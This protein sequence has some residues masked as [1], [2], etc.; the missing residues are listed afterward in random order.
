[1]RLAGILALAS[2]VTVTL[3]WSMSS[4]AKPVEPEALCRRS[5]DFTDGQ[6]EFDDRVIRVASTFTPGE[7]ELGFRKDSHLKVVLADS[8][9]VA[10]VTRTA[11]NEALIEAVRN[12]L[13]VHVEGVVRNDKV[14][15][16][17]LEMMGT[18]VDITVYRPAESVALIDVKVISTGA[19]RQVKGIAYRP[20]APATFAGA[21]DG[22]D[23]RVKTTIDGISFR[24]IFTPA[25]AV[26]NAT[27]HNTIKVVGLV[28]GAVVYLQ[29]STANKALLLTLQR[30]DTVVVDGRLLPATPGAERVVIADALRL[31]P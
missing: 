31:L 16:R 4:S 13:P 17:D 10:F 8:C 23:V 9:L 21:G 5:D 27:A 29:R 6:V 3:T 15:R 2:T 26:L 24:R 20:V 22:P 28:A 30:G 18:N 19:Y 7:E 14:A 1:M 11:D 25:D 12:G